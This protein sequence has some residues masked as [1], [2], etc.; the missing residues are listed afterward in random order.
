MHLTAKAN[1]NQNPVTAVRL[2]IDDQSV[3]TVST[4]MLDTTVPL[5]PGQHS[6]VVQG[7][8]WRG[9]VFKEKIFVT[10]Q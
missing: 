5:S 7:W 2:Y 9:Q 4:N 6:V 10:A 1:S 3:D 8:D